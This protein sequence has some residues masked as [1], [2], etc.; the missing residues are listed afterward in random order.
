MTQDGMRNLELTP[1]E[2]AT[3]RESRAAKAMEAA[4]LAALQALLPRAKSTRERHQLEQ[5]IERRGG[6]PVATCKCGQPVTHHS[7]SWGECN[8]CYDR[9]YGK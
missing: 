4:D 1:E 8:Y 3:I 2:V 9:G 7:G 5:M 6:P